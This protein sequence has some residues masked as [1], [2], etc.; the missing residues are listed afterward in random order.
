MAKSTKLGPGKKKCVCG[1]IL[2]ARTKIC[3]KCNHVFKPKSKPVSGNDDSLQTAALEYV[4]RSKQTIDEV[5]K[6][7][8]KYKVDNLGQIIAML[9][10]KEQ[11]QEFF[12]R[13]K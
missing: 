13:Y 9:G 8:E 7:I 1:E 3:P 11:A 4:V 5:L 6:D 10:G 12:S 2:G